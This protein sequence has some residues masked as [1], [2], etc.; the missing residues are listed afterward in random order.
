MMPPSQ[1]GVPGGLIY[2]DQPLASEFTPT[3]P[4]M[5]VNAEPI[6]EDEGGDQFFT[7][8]MAFADMEPLDS[9]GAVTGEPS[10]VGFFDKLAGLVTTAGS[11]YT[12]IQTAKYAAK[13]PVPRP[14]PA[15]TPPMFNQ[16]TIISMGLVVLG[17]LLLLKVA[18]GK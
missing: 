14:A 9:Y 3:Y 4:E 5:D 8:S 1:S 2:A 7:Y 12:D 10:Q 15:P 13:R 6:F 18:G 16:Q 11:K 17:G